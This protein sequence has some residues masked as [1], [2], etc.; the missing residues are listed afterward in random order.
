MAKLTTPDNYSLLEARAH[1]WEAYI[2]A[3][4]GKS[5]AIRNKQLQRLSPKELMA[6]VERLDAKIA[7]AAGRSTVVQVVHSRSAGR[8]Y[9]DI[10]FR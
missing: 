10:E 9:R 7:A 1:Y 4:Q 8:T 3:S 2:L 5:Y 6:E